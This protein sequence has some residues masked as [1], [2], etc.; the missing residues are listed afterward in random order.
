MTWETVTGE[1]VLGIHMSYVKEFKE[2]QDG[3][4]IDN[5]TE[6]EKR[7]KMEVLVFDIAC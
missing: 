2:L 6:R 3:S 1:W 4:F 5:W 7:L